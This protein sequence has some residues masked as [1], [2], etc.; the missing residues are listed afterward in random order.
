MQ[1]IT[2]GE[3]SDSGQVV[4]QELESFYPPL[5]PN[6]AMTPASSNRTEF[7]PPNHQVT[8]PPQLI[9]MG[10]PANYVIATFAACGNSL[11]PLPRGSLAFQ[12]NSTEHKRTVHCNLNVF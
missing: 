9:T 11:R 6:N 1:R 3:N 2:L 5:P 12:Y 8:A 10:G 7:Q 4:P